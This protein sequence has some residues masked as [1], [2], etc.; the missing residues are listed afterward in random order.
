M[1]IEAKDARIT[2][3]APLLPHRVAKAG[4]HAPQASFEIFNRLL[5]RIR[6]EHEALHGSGWLVLSMAGHDGMTELRQCLKVASIC[7]TCFKSP[8]CFF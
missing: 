5:A 8:A 6:P 4:E 3:V 2:V 7:D 1:R